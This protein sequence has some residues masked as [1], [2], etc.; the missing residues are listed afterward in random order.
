MYLRHGVHT[1][2]GAHW[3]LF[4]VGTE[5]CGA[6]HSPVAGVEFKVLGDMHTWVLWMYR[7]CILVN[8]TRNVSDI[9]SFTQTGLLV[10]ASHSNWPCC[11]RK[12]LSEILMTRIVTSRIT[13][14]SESFTLSLP[15]DNPRPFCLG[16]YTQEEW[17]NITRYLGFIPCK[18]VQRFDWLNWPIFFVRFLLF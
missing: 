11:G 6:D 18:Y 16:I 10:G 7:W 5:L 17:F 4:S 13:A 3:A 15:I 14:P 2:C 1:C 9:F 8:T 12:E